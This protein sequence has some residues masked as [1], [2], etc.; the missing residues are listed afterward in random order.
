MAE[1]IKIIKM[2]DFET[3]DGRIQRNLMTLHDFKNLFYLVKAQLA[4]EIRFDC[5]NYLKFTVILKIL[6]AWPT[7][8][9]CT[10]HASFLFI[11]TITQPTTIKSTVVGKLL[12]HYLTASI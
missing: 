7:M 3:S 6:I 8:L 5:S 10:Y 4:I 9:C 2:M 11:P 12:I 1:E